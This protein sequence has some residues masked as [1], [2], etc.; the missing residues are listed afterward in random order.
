MEDVHKSPDDLKALQDENQPLKDVE[1]NIFF[2][3][4]H[5]DEDDIE[6]EL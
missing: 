1:D 2:D 6:A 5:G 4:K 3:M